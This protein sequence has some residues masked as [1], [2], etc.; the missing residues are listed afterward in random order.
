MKNILIILTVTLF[1]TLTAKGQNLLFIGENS[2]PCTE[3]F[4]L[5]PNSDRHYINEL[6]VLFAKDGKTVLFVVSTETIDVLI[7]GK[8]VIYL[9]DG[10]V[11]TLTDKGNYDYVDRIASAVYYLTNEELNKMKNSNI[12]T[13]RYSL[14][15]EDGS[16]STFGGN[17]SASNKGTSTKTD[18]PALITEFFNK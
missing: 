9:D 18:V 13:I 5:Q 6:N 3:S 10:T 16:S 2:Y 14:E 1:I 17:F 12:N 8:L 15:K 7:R 4:I 11:L